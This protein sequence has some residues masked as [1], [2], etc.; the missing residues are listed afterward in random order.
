MAVVLDQL[1]R[2]W[3]RIAQDPRIAAQLP[4]VCR[5]AE[6]TTLAGLQAAV[7]E[8]SYADQDVV[9]LLLARRAVAGDALAAR[10]LLQLLW[11]GV[12]GLMRT[13]QA[14][15]DTDER[16]AAVLGAVYARICSYP[17]D[18]RPRAVAA[19]IVL[20]AA[21]EL[22]RAARPATHESVGRLDDLD[23]IIQPDG[24]MNAGEALAQ[25]V[26]DAVGTGALSSA[27]G[28]LILGT[29]LYG[30]PLSDFHHEPTTVRT[31]QRR[32]QQAERALVAAVA[33]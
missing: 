27:D 31:I 3:D 18:R 14:I 29:R 16:S 23:T 12:L 33:A 13:W 11:K 22:R 25:L 2:D 8:A 21:K 15:G 4:D 17:V 10:V 6:V 32:R 24:E 1:I 19:N 5:F 20:D 7:D 28:A 9:M 30:R 26:A